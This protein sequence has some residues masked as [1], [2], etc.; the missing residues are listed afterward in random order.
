MKPQVMPN[1]L[2][3]ELTN[4]CNM[5]CT[6][7]PSDLLNRKRQHMSPRHVQR[8]LQQIHALGIRPPILC[9]VLGEPLLNRQVFHYLDL[10]A[11]YGHPVTVI[12]NMTRLTD[13]T[14]LKRLLQY[15][16]LTIALSLQTPTKQSYKMRGYSSLPFADFFALVFQAIE[17]KFTQQSPVRLEV[18]I[19]SN[20]ILCHD[21]NLQTDIPLRLWPMFP[22]YKKEARW[23]KRFLD[24]LETFA[25][26]VS[27]TYP[28]FYAQEMTRCQELYHEHIGPKLALKRAHLPAD[29]IHLKGEDFWGYMF[30]PN[31][32]LQFKSFELWTKDRAFLKS[33]MPKDSF[34]YIEERATPL[35]C[36]MAGNLGML[37]NGDLI[38]CCLDYE[39]EM[40]LGN[41]ETADIQAL[42]SSPKRARLQENVVTEPLCRR[43]KGTVFVLGTNPLHRRKQSIDTYGSGWHPY[44]KDLHGIGGRWTN[45]RAVS[46]V[47]TRIRANAIVIRCASERDVSCTLALYAYNEADGSFS[48]ECLTS[49][50]AAKK[51]LTVKETAHNFQV[52]RLY[53]IVLA[54]PAFVPAELQSD[55]DTRRLGVAVF[56]MYLKK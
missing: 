55:G 38:F 47:Y 25:Q 18:H 26:Q 49:F 4:V 29:F 17:Q 32:L 56:A 6:F 8:F 36:P 54:S 30:L 11:Q 19:A 3:L 50:S 34:L 21:P 27:M 53:K 5:H 15:P 14:V 52:S 13:Q 46:Y 1:I 20:Y 41:I 39:G 48:R 28:D 23:A 10:F 35:A 40:K 51:Q 2:F 33:L 22:S 37:A 24:S 31:V 16:N 9:N 44:E 42:L 12:T 45:G 7:C 43:C